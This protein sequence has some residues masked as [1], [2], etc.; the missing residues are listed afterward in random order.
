MNLV[1]FS[2]FLLTHDSLSVFSTACHLSFFD[3]LWQ[4][5]GGILWW[6]LKIYYAYLQRR[7]LVELPLSVKIGKGC[8]FNHYGSRTFN[9]GTII[10]ENV[11]IFPS[12]LIGSVRGKTGVSVPRIGD[13][14]FLGAGCKILGGVHVG[15]YTFICPNSVVVKDV[16]DGDVVS[17]IPAKRLNGCGKKNVELYL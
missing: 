11:T 7:I 4:M 5:W 3:M 15:N 1:L 10:G 9:P 17:G 6:S 14:V 13:N 8:M 2:I 12:V 16:P